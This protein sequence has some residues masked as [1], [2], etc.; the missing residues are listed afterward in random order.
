[1]SRDNMYRWIHRKKWLRR[2]LLFEVFIIV[3]ELAMRMGVFFR[4]YPSIGGEV[5]IPIAAGL[6]WW[7]VQTV[8]QD[9][10]RERIAERENDDFAVQK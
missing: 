2:I 5:C 7:M 4:G 6:I 9:K 3:F 1:M 8:K 10:V